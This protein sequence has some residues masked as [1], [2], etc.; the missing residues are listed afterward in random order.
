MTEA[1][2]AEALPS[3]SA[4]GLLRANRAF[5]LLW[6]A[7]LVSFLGDS[8]GLVALILYVAD[9]S[10]TGAAVG[11]L[12]LA[13][14]FAPTLVGPLAGA[15]AD[16]LHRRRVML[17]CEVLQGFV[18]AAIVATT[19][20]LAWL[21]PLV[22]VRAALATTFQPASRSALPDLVADAD[23][24]RANALLGFGTWGLDA[25]GPLLAA[26]L[27]PLL[28]VRGLLAFDAVS[29]FLAVPFLLRLPALGP[30]PR[31]AASTL[32][33]DV[34]TGL[35]FV[36]DHRFVR[37]LV[38]G[39]A[40]IVAVG[41]VDDVALVLFAKG[42]LGGGDRLASVLYGGAGLGMLAGFLALARG[43]FGLTAR[44]A[45]VAGFVATNAATSL[46]GATRIAA[47]AVLAQVVRGLGISLVEV[48]H[49]VAIARHVPAHLRGRVFANLYAALGV[50]TG[51]AYVVGGRLVDATT[52]RAVLVVSGLL[53]L[54]VTAVLAWRLREPVEEAA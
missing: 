48:G 51:L 20:P 9:R 18:V 22:A 28:R 24:E 30:A 54:G 23:L 47:V 45:L 26:L 33:A 49:N 36:W 53:G 34:A 41:A 1:A 16:R 14:D 38:L 50:A 29:F 5:R 8:L 27:V 6:L 7:R 42:A 25:A 40:G 13:G 44:L 17:A 10:G 15:L 4:F 35:R 32:R 31:E 21:L 43:R 39:F 19:P 52:P 3:L 46:T 11:L 2:A 37:V 12:L